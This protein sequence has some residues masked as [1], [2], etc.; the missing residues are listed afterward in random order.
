L[1][2]AGVPTALFLTHSTGAGSVGLLSVFESPGLRSGY[3]TGLA[4]H[5]RL[6]VLFSLHLDNS[7][8]LWAVDDPSRPRR[9]TVSGAAIQGQIVHA[10]P[11]GSVLATLVDTSD[12]R[13]VNL[14]T[15][16]DL[17]GAV[18]GAALATL[19]RPG[20]PAD[21]MAFHPSGR[22]LA[23][24]GH[25][26]VGDATGPATVSLWDLANPATPALLSATVVDDASGVAFSPDGRILATGRSGTAAHVAGLWDVSDPRRLAPLGALTASADAVAGEFGADGRVMVTAGSDGVLRTWDVTDPHHPKQLASFTQ[27]LPDDFV[28]QESRPPSV[29]DLAFNPVAGRF[30]AT[31]GPDDKARLWNISDP[32]HPTL[33]ATLAGHAGSVSGVAFSHDGRVLATDSV[34]GTV[35]LWDTSRL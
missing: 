31:A 16:A 14:W 22:I 11:S 35:R 4:F 7:V 27:R 33:R 32:A 29:A 1:I 3:P 26:T 21:D 2:A 25:Q 12:G 23:V 19:G 20:L 13:Q 6:R 8:S 34:D 5:P 15:V 24:A 30:F 10:S 17:S 9:L 18:A 28:Q